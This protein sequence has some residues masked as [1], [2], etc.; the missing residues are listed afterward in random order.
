ME[1][2]DAIAPEPGDATEA[3]AID[4]CALL[5]G[6]E[7]KSVQG[8]APA[9]TRPGGK[10]DGRFSVSQCYFA[11]PVVTDSITLRVVQRASGADGQDP[12]KAWQETFHNGTASAAGTARRKRARQPQKVEGL[13]EEALWL[14]NLKSGGLYVLKGNSYIRIAVGGPDDLETKIKKASALAAMV[15]PR[16]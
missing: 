14:G 4:A 6:E 3:S 10:S 16:L 9:N 11:L 7:I 13:G 5:S 8:A 12:K 1:Q 2:A 15:L